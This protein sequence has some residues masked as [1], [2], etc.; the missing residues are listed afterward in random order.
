MSAIYFNDE[1]SLAQKCT[2]CAHLLDNGYKLPRCV[3][4]C[5]TD[6]LSFGEEEELKDLIAGAGVLKPETGAG[7]RVYYRN[8]PGRFIGGTVYDPV[9]KEVVIGA[10]CLLTTGGKAGRDLHRRLRRLLVQ[11]PHGGHVRRE[12]RG[13]GLRGQVL[14]GSRHGQGRQ[15]GRHTA[16]EEV[17]GSGKRARQETRRHRGRSGRAPLGPVYKTGLGGLNRSDQ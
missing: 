7:P 16:C 4:A 2:G 10:R 17:G 8:I 12:H 9:A 15:S 1:L 5:P 6:A 14:L 11:G 13:Q 3:E